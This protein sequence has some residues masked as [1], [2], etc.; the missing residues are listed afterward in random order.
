MG[1]V[2][3]QPGTDRAGLRHHD[4]VG[5]GTNTHLF[6][7]YNAYARC[8]SVAFLLR[9]AY[10]RRGHVAGI[11]SPVCRCRQGKDTAL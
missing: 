5:L 7:P 4:R 8:T 6:Q 2:L 11:G 10:L 3:Y 1:I 9:R